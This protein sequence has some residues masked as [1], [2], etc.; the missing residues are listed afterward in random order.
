[1]LDDLVRFSGGFMSS[2][3][4]PMCPEDFVDGRSQHHATGVATLPGSVQACRPVSTMPPLLEG[5]AE[6]PETHP[7]QIF[8]ARISTRPARDE[9]LAPEE[10]EA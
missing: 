6:L 3:S 7:S 10:F 2:S 8:A 5:I 9:T 4:C 1:M